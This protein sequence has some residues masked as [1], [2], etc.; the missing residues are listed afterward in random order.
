M[1]WFPFLI[2]S[3]AV[4]WWVQIATSGLHVAAVRAAGSGHMTNV[5]LTCDSCIEL[6]I[7]VYSQTLASPGLNTCT[8]SCQ[9]CQK[10]QRRP[11]P[12]KKHLQTTIS[13]SGPKVDLSPATW[14][15]IAIG[16]DNNPMLR[17]SSWHGKQ[18]FV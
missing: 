15:E 12:L 9:R 4:F 3:N 18:I 10:G 11:K 13:S 5:R 7:T 16:A 1:M 14:Q 6:V 2:T 8:S 17:G